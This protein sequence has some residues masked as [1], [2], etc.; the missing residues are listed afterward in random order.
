M[1]NQVRFLYPNSKD[2]IKEIQAIGSDTYAEQIFADKKELL[3]IKVLDIRIEAANILKQEL[4]SIGADAVVPRSAISGN[5]DRTNVILLLTRRQI[6]KLAER[7]KHQ[8]FS[9]R[10]LCCEINKKLICTT[11]W[12]A[13]SKTI[14][15]TVPKIMGILNVTPDSFYDGGKYSDGTLIEKRIYDMLEQG[16]DIIDIGAESTRPGSDPVSEE[17]EIA[18]IKPVLKVIHKISPDSLI[19]IDTTKSA[20]ATVALEEGAH[21]INDISGL[22][23]DPVMADT[24]ARFKAAVIIMHCKGIPKNMQSEPCYDDVMEEI[25]E[26][27]NRQINLSISAGIDMSSIA[28]DP[29]IG[30][31]KRVEDNTTI[32]RRLREYKSFGIPIVIGLSRKSFLGSLTGKKVDERLPATI[33]AHALALMHGADILRVHDVAEAKDAIAVIR[34][35]NET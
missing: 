1:T 30:F 15:I 34:G 20:V 17:E 3:I 29:G 7:L 31:G 16:A 27:I 4:L 11:E 32:L 21:I 24:I 33:A 28:L 5:P 35:I 18:R 23:N 9:L 25:C 12:Q 2:W 19:S 13:R 26:F 22:R 10:E 6:S 14:D 8:P